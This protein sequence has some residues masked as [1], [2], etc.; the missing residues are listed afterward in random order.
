MGIPMVGMGVPGPYTKDRLILSESEK[1]AAL[2]SADKEKQLA[3]KDLFPQIKKSYDALV[4]EAKAY[5]E[6]VPEWEDFN[7]NPSLE[8]IDWVASKANKYRYDIIEELKKEA[9]K[10]AKN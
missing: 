3:I 7:G 8:A 10:E 6:D 9:I 5:G 4:P 1:Q 2:I